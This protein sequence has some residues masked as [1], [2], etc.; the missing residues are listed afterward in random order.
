MLNFRLLFLLTLIRLVTSKVL[1]KVTIGLGAFIQSVYAAARVVS[2]GSTS[3]GI[4]SSD[5][6]AFLIGIAVST[7]CYVIH[8]RNL[9]NTGLVLRHIQFLVFFLVIKSHFLPP[10]CK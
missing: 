10:F 3:F 5:Y 6:S 8:F 9:Y 1:K 2:F 7:D 4:I